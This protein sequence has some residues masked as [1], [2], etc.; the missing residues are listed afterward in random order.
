MKSLS[1]KLPRDALLRTYKSFARSHLDYSHIVYHKTN[2]E[3]F[4]SKL[5]RVQNMASPAMTGV[6]QGTSYEC[7][8]KELG[9]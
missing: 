1:N 8:N 2:N 7:P 3:S 9:L 4:T 6:I 5:E